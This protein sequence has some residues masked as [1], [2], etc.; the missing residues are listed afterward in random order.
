MWALGKS[1]AKAHD[2]FI[3]HA[4]GWELLCDCLDT[5]KND[6]PTLST[7]CG[8]VKDLVFGKGGLCRMSSCCDP[9]HG[10]HRVLV[11]LLGLL[12]L[13]TRDFTHSDTGL[14]ATLLTTL[15]S[16]ARLSSNARFIVEQGDIATIFLVID[17]CLS[18]FTQHLLLIDRACLTIE[19]L[20]SNSRANKDEDNNNNHGISK[21]NVAQL[22][23]LVRCLTKHYSAHN[24]AKEGAYTIETTTSAMA[25]LCRV[26][27]KDKSQISKTNLSG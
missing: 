17:L 21:N 8:I 10:S 16:M 20:C 5:F 22:F 24:N 12:R 1:T 3:K 26:V 14:I 23:R 15:R 9:N 25:V 7:L 18:T 2:V 11:K 6:R 27:I 4:K 19:S 13:C